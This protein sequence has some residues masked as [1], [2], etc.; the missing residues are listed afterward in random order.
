[1]DSTS[2]I[3]DLQKQIIQLLCN[4][5]IQNGVLPHTVFVE[6]EDAQ[7]DPTY[8]KYR[9]ISIN[10]K[11]ETC[12]L[13]NTMGREGTFNL[14]D[15][16]IE[17]LSTVLD[18]CHELI[19]NKKQEFPEAKSSKELWAFLYPIGRFQHNTPDHRIIN[20]YEKYNHKDPKVE[21][22]TPDEL[23]EMINDGRFNDLEY[24]LRF[25]ELA[26]HKTTPIPQF[27]NP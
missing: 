18:R 5:K 12:I 13:Q 25:I 3:R 10:R 9:L 22:L 1:M 27:G 20:G 26:T 14:M 16:N 4:T 24:Y 17:W 21:K 23:A 8:T 19:P 6:E 15:I 7:G 2:K 11:E